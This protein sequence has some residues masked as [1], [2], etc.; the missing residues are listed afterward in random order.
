MKTATRRP[1]QRLT[2]DDLD[3]GFVQACSAPRQE[4]AAAIVPLGAS[5]G[6]YILAGDRQSVLLPGDMQHNIY[7]RTFIRRAESPSEA[8]YLLLWAVLWPSEERPYSPKA[9]WGRFDG[10]PRPL[11]PSD[12][13]ILSADTALLGLPGWGGPF[14]V[15]SGHRQRRPVP[16]EIAPGDSERH[17]SHCFARG[18]AESKAPGRLVRPAASGLDPWHPGL[19]LPQRRLLRGRLVPGSH[20]VAC[21]RR[22]RSFN[23]GSR[24][25][26]TISRFLPA[27][28]SS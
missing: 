17:A 22:R 8:A 10:L 20:P 25:R 26:V 9:L 28:V 14:G 23:S 15:V 4:Q 16:Y 6:R 1:Q 11:E 7:Y 27:R 3:V 12:H 19:G 21:G 24:A 18:V 5:P 13:E 2:G